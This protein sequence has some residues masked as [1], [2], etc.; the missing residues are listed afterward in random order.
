MIKINSMEDL[1]KYSKELPND[2]VVDIQSRIGDWIVSGG[3]YEDDYIKQQF[4]Y[5][6]RVLNTKLRGDINT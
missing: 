4:R 1:I 5:A 2:V 6:E 3:S